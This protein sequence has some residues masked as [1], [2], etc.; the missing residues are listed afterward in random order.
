M[1]RIFINSH[2]QDWLFLINR[3]LEQAGFE[4]HFV[5][6]AESLQNESPDLLILDT[7][8]SDDLQKWNRTFDSESL[9]SVPVFVASGDY[10]IKKRAL[11]SGAN[12]FLKKPFQTTNLI[13]LINK[14]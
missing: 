7:K 2:D 11:S 8:S 3:S 1:K 14:L 13:S 9:S 6:Q 12:E 5:E 10:T 4:V